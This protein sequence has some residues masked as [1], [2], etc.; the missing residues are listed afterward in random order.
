MIDDEQTERADQTGTLLK[1]VLH[2]TKWSNYGGGDDGN[3]CS[4][5]VLFIF[6]SF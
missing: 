6:L 5:A 3:R 1:Y 2:S 4:F